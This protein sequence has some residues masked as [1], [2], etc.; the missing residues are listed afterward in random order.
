MTDI[1]KD[2][3]AEDET[4]ADTNFSSNATLTKPVLAEDLPAIEE[5]Q[6]SV[7][8]FSTTEILVEETVEILP[9]QQSD[10]IIMNSNN[11]N[12]VALADKSA[13]NFSRKLV[14][15]DDDE[16]ADREDTNVNKNTSLNEHEVEF[17]ATEEI[18]LEGT[19]QQPLQHATLSGKRLSVDKNSANVI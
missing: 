19:E 17:E 14:L 1:A 12:N 2:T 18:N 15:T 13:D 16:V 3:I 9:Q 5:T 4:E 8:K 7:E 10:M 11:D 6:S